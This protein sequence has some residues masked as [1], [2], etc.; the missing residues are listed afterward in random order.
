MRRECDDRAVALSLLAPAL[1]GVY[2]RFLRPAGGPALDFSIP[3]GEPSLCPPDSVSWRVC[4]NPVTLLIG[5][6]AAVVMELAEPRVRAGVWGHTTFRSAPVQRLRRTGLATM[7]TVYGA[8][9]RAEAMIAGI[10]R[11]H[12]AVRGVTPEG[13]AYDA[14]DPELLDW[15]HAT[16]AIGFLDAWH[17]H[18]RPLAPAERDGYVAE[19]RTAG[20]LYGATWAPAC[21]ADWHALLERMLPRLGPSPVIGE[22]LRILAAAPLLPL[23]L[24]PLQRLLL[25]A[26]V[27]RVPAAVRLRIGPVGAAPLGRAQRR[28]VDAL[29]RAADALVLPSSPPVQACR[30]LGLP[31]GWL[32]AAGRGL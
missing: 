21:E 25:R 27:E 26:A 4:K 15:V 32:Y 9:S 5:G 13:L 10:A 1:D 17:A 14:T 7:V 28:V 23:P 19:G 22:F 29:A 16:A 30:R 18:V 2:L 11:R 20:A 24:R 3:P 8:R 6:V 31:D 12:A